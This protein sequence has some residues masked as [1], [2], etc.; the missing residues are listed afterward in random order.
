M[1][2]ALSLKCKPGKQRNVLVEKIVLQ[3]SSEARQNE[4]AG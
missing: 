2:A 1:M 3:T 4:Q